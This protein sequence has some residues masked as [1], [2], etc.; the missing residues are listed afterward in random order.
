MTPPYRRTTPNARN[1]RNR[2]P[3]SPLRPDDRHPAHRQ[4]KNPRNRLPLSPPRPFTRRSRA[5][6]TFLIGG[7]GPAPPVCLRLPPLK[8]PQRSFHRYAQRRACLTLTPTKPC[9]TGGEHRGAAVPVHFVR[10]PKA[11]SVVANHRAVGRGGSS[12]TPIRQELAR[13]GTLCVP[14]LQVRIRRLTL[15]FKEHG[16]YRWVRAKHETDHREPGARPTTRTATGSIFTSTRRSGYRSRKRRRRS[17]I[18]RR[19]L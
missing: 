9:M 1:P 13:W 5:L 7:L 6:S 11:P 8:L 16:I 2:L 3:L 19:N 10:W 4:R 12:R 17:S 14:K 15:V 18:F